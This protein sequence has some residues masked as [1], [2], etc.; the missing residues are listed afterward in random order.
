MNLKTKR[1]NRKKQTK[2]NR[3]SSLN[4]SNKKELYELYYETGE[5][6]PTL[7]KIREVDR[8]SNLKGKKKVS[9]NSKMKQEKV[10]QN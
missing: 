10:Y 5:Y 1:I 4:I 6:S 7:H 3:L 2:Q 8:I 9:M